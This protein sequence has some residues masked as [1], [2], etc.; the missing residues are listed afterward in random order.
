MILTVDIGNTNVVIGC[1]D[2]NEQL[3]FL[4][5]LSTNRQRSAADYLVRLHQLLKLYH[6]K[7]AQICGS[8]LSSVVPPV[9]ESMSNAI[10]RLTGAAPLIVGPGIRTG[11]NLCM[12]QPALVGSDLIVGAVAAIHRYPLPLIMID[13]G[14][15]TTF[16]AIDEQHNYLGTIILPGV[17]TAMDS[18][19]SA[20]A[21][22]PRIALEAPAHVLGKNTIASMQSG[23][24]YGNASCIDGM[25][26]R[27]EQELGKKTTVVATGGLAPAITRHCLH[28]IITDDTL[29]LFGLLKLYQLNQ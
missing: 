27:I 6:L 19:S 3:L 2:E 25:I 24:V 18:L 21:Q 15:A 16:S 23:A 12:D 1:F 22:L 26:D 14:T 20:A 7:G 8:V 10:R 13:L 29:L 17:R 28:E 5:R 11:L 9:T 4:E